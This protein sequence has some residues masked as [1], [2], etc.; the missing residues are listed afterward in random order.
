MKPIPIV[1]LI[2][3]GW[4]TRQDQCRNIIMFPENWTSVECEMCGE[5]YHKQGD[6]FVSEHKTD[7]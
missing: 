7:F 2:C 5:K 3:S 1:S 6:E 4:I